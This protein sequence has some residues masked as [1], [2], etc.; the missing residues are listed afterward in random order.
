MSADGSDVG[1]RS[2]TQRRRSATTAA[3]D[4]ASDTPIA[5]TKGM[6]EPPLTA[7]ATTSAAADTRAKKAMVVAYPSSGWLG[8]GV[9][10]GCRGVHRPFT[11]GEGTH[12]SPDDF[13]L[14][15]LQ[16][17][18]AFKSA[19]PWPPT[20][21]GVH[22]LLAEPGGVGAYDKESV[23]RFLAAATA[24]RNRLVTALEAARLRKERAERA[25][26]SVAA[27]L[28]DLTAAARREIDAL[29]AAA[30]AEA[31][32]VLAAA[33]LEAGDILARARMSAA[34]LPKREAG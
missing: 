10:K 30:E 28:A 11:L 16:C 9:P 6:V 31:E 1:R 13:T 33:E 5:T 14:R 21:A 8:R 27:R 22:G 7:R 24:E 2:G 12:C 26:T 23:D 29:R 3:D 17:H 18:P 15:T 20:F 19:S 34:E 25:P 32:A 4:A